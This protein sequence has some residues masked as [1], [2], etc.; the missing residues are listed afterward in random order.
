MKYASIFVLLMFVFSSPVVSQT[1]AFPGAEGFGKFTTGGRDGKVLI[2]TNLHDDGPGSLRK[3]IQAKYP[4]IIVFAVSGTIGLE[5]PLDINNGDVTIAGQ[6]APGDGICIRNFTVNIKADNVIIRFLRFRMGDEKRYEG[7]ALS[8]NRGKR[9]IIIDHCSMSWSTDEC[10]SFYN[11]ENFTLQW[12]IISE[13]LNHSIHTKG[14]HGYGGIWGGKKASFHHNLLASHSSRLPRFSGSAST[15]NGPDELVDFRNNVIYNWMSNNI[16]GGERG[17]YNIINNY[18][19][20]GP[21]TKSSVR[22]R[23][24]NPWRPYGRFYV[25][26]NVLH[27][28]DIVTRDNRSGIQGGDPDSLL[29]SQEFSVAAI[30]TQSAE[31]A[32][33]HI[34]DAAGASLRRDAVDARV[35]QEVRDGNSQG[36]SKQN[37]IINSQSDVGA[38]PELKSLPAPADGDSDGMPDEWE[39]KNALDPKDASDAGKR[40]IQEKYD[41]IEVYL[42]GLV[43]SIVRQQR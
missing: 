22:G 8:G 42:N 6:S 31:V 27:D 35:V 1:P 2:V 15:P 18:L 41:N 26:G 13:S 28:N 14:D 25:S 3:A 24:M 23:L 36:G 29:V 40:T 32:C 19:K 9:N 20:A 12:C 11:N 37:G 17:K 33:A 10:A 43:D 4:R 21:S 7:D 30:D 39:K 34:L 16:Y 38:W 5:S